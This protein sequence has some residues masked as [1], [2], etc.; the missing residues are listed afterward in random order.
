MSNRKPKRNNI[1]P[2]KF[3]LKTKLDKYTWIVREGKKIIKLTLHPT[4]GYRRSTINV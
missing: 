3:D 1:R 2:S 4:K